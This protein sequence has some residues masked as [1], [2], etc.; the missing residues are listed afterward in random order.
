MTQCHQA[1]RGLR[2]G[3]VLFCTGARSLESTAAAVDESA[4]PPAASQPVDYERDI[5]PI[6]ENSCFRCHGPERPKSHF[7][8]DNREAALKGGDNGVDIIPGKS[9]Q[10]PLIHYV[11]R[12]VADME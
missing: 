3:I 12:L 2:L 1:R 6:F 8:L 10:S 11:A 4:L 9:A 7:R 5:K